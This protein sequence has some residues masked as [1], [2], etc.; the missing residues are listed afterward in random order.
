MRINLNQL[1][2]F[3]LVARHKSMTAAANLLYVSKPA[4][5]MQIKKMEGWLGFP[6]FERLQNELRLT[7]RGKAL[8]NAI[9]PIFSKLE[10]LE[11]YIEDIVRT[12]EVE[13]KLGTHHLPG[14]YF[15]PDLIAHVQ[16]KYPKLK[17]Q[18]ELGT[19]DELLEKLF[20]QKLD[21]ALF[22]GDLPEDA[23]CRTIHLFDQDLV[24]VVAAGGELS[25]IECVSA[26]KDLAAVP[27]ILQQKGTGALRAVLG[28]L[29]THRVKPNILFDNLSSDVIK[30]FLLKMQAGAFISRFIVQKE[31]DAGLFH[32]IKILEE[33]PICRFQLAYLDK[34]YIPMKIEHFI[35][36]IAGFTPDFQARD[37]SA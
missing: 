37:G 31:L 12:E 7:E 9:E 1:C 10:E 30:Q 4:V 27:L 17:V 18:M 16:T 35:D 26:Q 11:L 36:G 25:K 14:N 8:Y 5:T 3:Y 21:L 19:Q 22:I 32:E 34:Q 6:V 13:I 23:K 2:V 29:E 15:I 24:L 20:Q 28:F 33:S